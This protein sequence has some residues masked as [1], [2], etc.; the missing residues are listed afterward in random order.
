MLQ[1]AIDLQ[2]WGVIAAILSTA[3]AGISVLVVIAVRIGRL[4][5][6]VE[7]HSTDIV[8]VRQKVGWHN[9]DIFNM[10]KDIAVL[11]ERADGLDEDIADVKRR[12]D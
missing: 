9:T 2:G 6:I 5:G 11:E 7:T 10:K 8:H 4:L 3:G 1:A 12:L